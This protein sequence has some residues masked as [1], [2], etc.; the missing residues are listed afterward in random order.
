MSSSS[1]RLRAELLMLK[2]KHKKLQIE[3]E[4]K[5][6]LQKLSYVVCSNAKMLY[7]KYFNHDEYQRIMRY[8]ILMEAINSEKIGS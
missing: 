1:A 6:T 5:S 8:K 2:S 4:K 7:L 3:F